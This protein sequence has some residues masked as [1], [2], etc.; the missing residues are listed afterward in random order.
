MFHYYRH[1]GSFDYFPVTINGDNVTDLVTH[2]AFINGRKVAFASRLK[3]KPNEIT[4]NLSGIKSGAVVEL[5][6]LYYHNDRVKIGNSNYSSPNV[7][8]KTTVQVKVP[9]KGKTVSLKYFNSKLDNGS[10]LISILTWISLII[11]YV[12]YKLSGKKG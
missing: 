11:I 10:M 9:R 1:N 5:P 12:K 8:K 2:H 3:S 6:I 7:T 4:Y